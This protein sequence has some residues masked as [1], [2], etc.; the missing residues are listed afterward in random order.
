MP[1]RAHLNVLTNNSR[2]DSRYVPRAQ[3][4]QLGS[5]L[6]INTVKGTTR[7]PNLAREGRGFSQARGVYSQPVQSLHPTTHFLGRG[8]D[9]YGCPTPDP[10]LIPPI[11]SEKH[12]RPLFNRA[13]QLL[14]SSTQVG[15]EKQ[16]TTPCEQ[17]FVIYSYI[18]TSSSYS[19][20]RASVLYLSRIL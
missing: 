7:L 15:R 10:L 8:A 20:I 19:G 5:K 17:F 1:L 2:S 9:D 13:P 18:S 16:K 11:H 4:L 3:C 14:Y 12:W 6:N